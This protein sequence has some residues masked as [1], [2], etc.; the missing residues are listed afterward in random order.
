MSRA[1][2]QLALDVFSKEAPF[3]PYGTAAIEALR[4]ALAQPS[5]PVLASLPNDLPDHGVTHTSLA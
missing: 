1:A 5:E 3:I 2:M 4:A